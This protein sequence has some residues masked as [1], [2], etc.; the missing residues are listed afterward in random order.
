MRSIINTLRRT[1]MGLLVATIVA[2]G[3]VVSGSPES[4]EPV[5]RHDVKLMTGEVLPT[6]V[7]VTPTAARGARFQTLNPD[8]PTR[9]DFVAGQAVTTAIGP[10]GGTLLILTSGFNRNSGPEAA[11]SPRNRTNTCLFTMFRAELRSNGRRSR[12]QTHS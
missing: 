2:S 11:L 8:L 6:G 10:D 9:P 5:A 7:R 12:F 4:S 3:P 1:G